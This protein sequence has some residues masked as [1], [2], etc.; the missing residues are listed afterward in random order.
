MSL[1][2]WVVICAALGLGVWIFLSMTRPHEPAIESIQ[3]SLQAKE[4]VRSMVHK[5]NTQR[6]PG[7][8]LDAFGS[9][10]QS[11]QRK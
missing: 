8:A 1:G 3:S 4:Q 7:Q 2:K 5:L 9:A 11:D 6:D 10:T